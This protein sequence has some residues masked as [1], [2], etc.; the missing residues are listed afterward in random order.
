MGLR[1]GTQV[2]DS[3]VGLNQRVGGMSTASVLAVDSGSGAS[4]QAAVGYSQPC[5][6]A[7]FSQTGDEV[8][9]DR[10]C[11]P[12]YQP[13]PIGVC[14]EDYF[15]EFVEDE[16]Q[17][18][19]AFC[20]TDSPMDPIVAACNNF[21]VNLS[22]VAFLTFR[23]NLN[24]IMKTPFNTRDDWV[25]AAQMCRLTGCI[26]LNIRNT[27][28]EFRPNGDEYQERQ[29]YTGYRFEH[30]STRSE[31][32][33]QGRHCEGSEF[34]SIVKTKLG[35]NRLIIAAEVD[36]QRIRSNGA[37]EYVELKTTR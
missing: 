37:K 29:C 34:C 22:E 13:A 8:T 2:W 20:S 27:G 7:Y 11:L 18:R 14:L 5:E 21:R 17:A 30:L 35:N 19:K 3:G 33:G 24:K 32:V 1:C 23:N 6:V 28:N 9:F 25:L 31:R 26:Y 4:S 10:S 12:L 36:C 15:D 16:E